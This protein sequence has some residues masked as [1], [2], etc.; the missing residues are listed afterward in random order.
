MSG[1]YPLQLAA[2]VKKTA[3]KLPPYGLFNLPDDDTLEPVPTSRV[4]KQE[5]NLLF[6]TGEVVEKK[7]GTTTNPANVIGLGGNILVVK[8]CPKQVF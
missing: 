4:K 3:Q 7:W 1:T 8:S 6:E 2:S 5:N